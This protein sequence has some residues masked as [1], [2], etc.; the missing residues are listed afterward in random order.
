MPQPKKHASTRAR[1]NKAPTAASLAARTDDERADVIVPRL[2]PLG[3]SDTGE[4]LEWS[5]R[6][7]EWWDAV[8]RSPM[9]AE[10]DRSDIH[11]LYILAR[12]IDSFWH[13]PNAALAAEIRLQRAGFGMTPYDRRRLEWTIEQADE[14]KDKG[15]RR[16]ANAGTSQQPDKAT[17]PRLHLVQ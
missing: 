7:L 14:A 13:H 10:Y 17:D 4:T 15:A 6:T 3:V 2:P 8:W 9:G 12:L 16:R 11:Q 5:E 1:A